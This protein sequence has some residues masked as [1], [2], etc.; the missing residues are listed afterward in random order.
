MVRREG[1]EEI[2]SEGPKNLWDE[3]LGAPWGHGGEVRGEGEA[4]RELGWE[5][6]P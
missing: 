5:G 6:R 3:E 2:E 1:R 4:P